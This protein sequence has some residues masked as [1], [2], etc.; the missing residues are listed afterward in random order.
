MLARDPVAYSRTK[1]INVRYHYIHELISYGKTTVEYIPTE[2]IV[3]DVLT[4]P[5]LLAAFR[6]CIKGI[7][8][9]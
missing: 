3:V 8:D 4:K 5:L 6:R 9:L 1:H 2:E 7:F